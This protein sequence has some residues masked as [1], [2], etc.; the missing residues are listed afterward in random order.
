MPQRRKSVFPWPSSIFHGWWIVAAT[1]TMAFIYSGFYFYDFTLFVT[2]IMTD[3]PEVGAAIEPAFLVAGITGALLSPLLGGF[4]DRRGPKLVVGGGL[5]LGAAGFAIMGVMTQPWHVYVGLTF[6]S[7][8]PIVIWAGGIPAV[9]NWFSRLQGRALGMTMVGLGLGGILTRP[10]LLVMETIGWRDS[11]LV[12]AAVILVILLPLVLVLRR[13][14]E[15]Y[16]MRPDG[17]PP[18]EE[19]PR[20]AAVFQAPVVYG[21][22]FTQILRAPTFWML[23]GLL[24]LAFWPIGAL[25]VHQSPYMES[26]GYSRQAAAD[27]VGA[28]AV[29]TIVGRLGGGWLADLTD[30]RRATVLALTLQAVGIAAFAIS[31]PETPYPLILFLLAF[32]PGFGGITV[33]QSALLATYF[34]RRSFG[35]AQGVL[36]TVTSVA[37]SL[38]PLVARQSEVFLGGMQQGFLMFAAFSVASAILV[39]MLLPRPGIVRVRADAPVQEPVAAP[40]A[41]RHGEDR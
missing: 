37:F 18:D 22:T 40:S 5:L 25:Q 8:G 21:L 3:I 13:R 29:I 10:S 32:A 12:M 41:G 27:A 4:F 36:W 11:F 33:L 31:R 6:A 7:L 38:S 20:A 19:E 24:F 28:M 17:A 15:D 2:P 35:A 14:P 39:Y 23:A 16:G 1:F 26:V 9:V 34:G 30:P